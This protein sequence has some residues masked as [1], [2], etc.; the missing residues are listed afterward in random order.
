ML[1][2]TELIKNPY[3][4]IEYFTEAGKFRVKIPDSRKNQTVSPLC[5][6]LQEAMQLRDQLK[7]AGTHE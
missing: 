1:T 3:A 7:A 6:T 5:D 2:E 4:D